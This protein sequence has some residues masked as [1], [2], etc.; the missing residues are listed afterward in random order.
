MPFWSCGVQMVA[1]NYQTADICMQLNRAMFNRGPK[2]GIILK[3]SSG[4][5]GDRVVQL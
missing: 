1:L 3:V 4:G 2:A 5:D